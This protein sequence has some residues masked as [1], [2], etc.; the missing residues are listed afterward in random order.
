MAVIQGLSDTAAHLSL[1]ACV[2]ISAVVSVRFLFTSQDTKRSDQKN[3]VASSKV[4]IR[5]THT[6]AAPRSQYG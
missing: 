6:N 2:G 3:R 5:V 4:D 1:A